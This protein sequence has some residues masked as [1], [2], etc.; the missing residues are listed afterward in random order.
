MSNKNVIKVTIDIEQEIGT[1]DVKLD[2]KIDRPPTM[3]MSELENFEIY[4]VVVA[5]LDGIGYI[6]DTYKII[7]NRD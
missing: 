4:K 7:D 3:L 6:Y 1:T 2:I 5:A